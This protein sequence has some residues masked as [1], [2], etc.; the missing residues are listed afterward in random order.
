MIKG[1]PTESEMIKQLSEINKQNEVSLMKQLMSQFDSMKRDIRHL[2]INTGSIESSVKS[3]DVNE[4]RVT[5]NE[6]EM[7]SWFEVFNDWI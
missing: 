5:I 2:K 6:V 4:V 7:K 1:K 3:L